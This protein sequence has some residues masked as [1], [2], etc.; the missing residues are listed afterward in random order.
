MSRDF[1]SPFFFFRPSI[2]KGNLMERKRVK[3]EVLVDI[4][5]LPGAF[6][7]PAAAVEAVRQILNDRIS[8][9]NPTVYL[10]VALP[11][12]PTTRR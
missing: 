10:V 6:D 4:D 5:P 2:Q 7:S 11:G 9:Y 8:H 3:L 12:V 1:L